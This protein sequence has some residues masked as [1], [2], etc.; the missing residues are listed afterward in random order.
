M[1]KINTICMAILIISLMAVQSFA[2]TWPTQSLTINWEYTGGGTNDH[3]GIDIAPLTRGVEGDE[4]YAFYRGTI[5]KYRY[6][7]KAGYTSHIA[8]N[9]PKSTG[10]VDKYMLSR[11]QHQ[12]NPANYSNLITSGSVSEGDLIGYMGKTG[13][14]ADGVHLHFETL[15]NNKK[16]TSKSG[17]Y[18]G[19]FVDPLFFSTTSARRNSSHQTVQAL[20]LSTET[21]KIGITI[22]NRFYDARGLAAMD[23][24]DLQLHSISKSQIVNLLP[25]LQGKP[26][27]ADAYATLA[28]LVK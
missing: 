7:S 22:D 25:I 1:K 6:D 20:P 12:L 11:N 17:W 28:K 16:Y 19:A 27:Y 15:V 10:S 26:E 14:T 2:I 3:T 9:N 5:T 23:D 13:T 24:S 21:P 8:H 4:I 18:D